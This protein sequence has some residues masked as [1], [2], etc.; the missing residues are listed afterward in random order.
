MTKNTPSLRHRLEYLGLRF[1]AWV[2][3]RLPYSL[4]PPLADLVGAGAYWLDS[5]GRAV[6]LSNLKAAFGDEMTPA[7]RQEVAMKSYQTFARTMLELFWSPNLTRENYRDY[8]RIE[9]RGE[10]NPP[11]GPAI[12]FCLHFGNFEWLSQVGAYEIQTGPMVMQRFKNPLLTDFFAKLRASSGHELITQERAL[13]K[14]LK[15][16][17]AGG[18]FGALTDLNIDPREGAVIIECFGLKTAVTPIVGALTQRTGAKAVP[19]EA[20]LD[21]DGIWRM[22]Y[23]EPISFSPDQSLAEIA[24]ICWNKLE[25]SIREQPHLWLW[26]YKHWRYRPE[27]TTREY[28]FYANI[29]KRFEKLLAES[30]NQGR[31]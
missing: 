11:E 4:I 28:P 10:N 24:Q 16:L 30:E 19:S 8:V 14:M 31:P 13:I 7:R 20:R 3:Q 17:K 15:F 12:Y 6:A 22:V 25:P 1:C 18:K 27:K 2:I 9:T 21:P 29:A 5:H 26:P 23:H